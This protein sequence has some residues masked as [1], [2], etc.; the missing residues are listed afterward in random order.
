MKVDFSP[1]PRLTFSLLAIFFICF[2]ALGQEQ[3]DSLKRVYE[4]AQ[5]KDLDP[6]EK[7]IA[8]KNI[9]RAYES[10]YNFDSALVYYQAQS[11]LAKKG[12]KNQKIADS[13]RFE[14]YM[15][16]G[17]MS[18]NQQRN[19]IGLTYLDSAIV[20]AKELKLKTKLATA[21]SNKAILYTNTS[22]LKEAIVLLVEARE[23]ADQIED[24]SDR[25]FRTQSILINIG[26]NY[27]MLEDYKQALTY[28]KEAALNARG[29]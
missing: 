23:L 17:Y 26:R 1:L 28:T 20:L 10:Q 7:F 18:I 16:I 4:E 14:S 29:K 22:Q 12:L 21:L 3:I 15:D 2:S 27:L 24:E 5:A 25:L 19:D 9:G 13:L 6:V 8:L 11:S